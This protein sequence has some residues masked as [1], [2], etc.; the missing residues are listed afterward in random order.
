MGGGGATAGR[1][2][3]WPCRVARKVG[4]VP[5]R[6]GGAGDR[7]N[8]RGCGQHSIGSSAV[9]QFAHVLPDQ[10]RSACT[11]GWFFACLKRTLRTEL[12]QVHPDALHV[13]GGQ[14]VPAAGGP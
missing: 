6:V 14:L 12:V 10:R 2:V 1:S 11:G 3:D 4:S 5:I 7:R 13:Y 8:G 9:H